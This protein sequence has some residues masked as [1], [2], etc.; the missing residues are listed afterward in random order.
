MH[1]HI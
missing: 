1:H